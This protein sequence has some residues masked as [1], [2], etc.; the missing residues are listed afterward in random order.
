MEYVIEGL[1]GIGGFFLQPLLYVLILAAA[2]QGWWRVQRE[3]RMF[4]TRIQDAIH[5]LLHLLWPSS[6]AALVV[7]AVVLLFGVGVETNALW[8]FSL[9]VGIVALCG[10]SGFL[11]AAY[12][13]SVLIFLGWTGQVSGLVPDWMFISPATTLSLALLMALLLWAEWWLIRRKQTASA[14]PTIHRS[15]R[16]KWKGRQSVKR[17]WLLPVMLLVPSGEG[18]LAFGDYWPLLSLP[19]VPDFPVHFLL[20]PLPIGLHTSVEGVA[21]PQLKDG[22]SQKVAWL[23]LFVSA[24]AI[25]ALYFPL[26]SLLAA[27]IAIGGRLTIT[28]VSRNNDRRKSPYYTISNEGLRVLAILPGTPAEDMEILVGELIQRVNDQ[29]VTSENEFY[30]ALHINRAYTKMQVSDQR[31]EPRFVQRAFFENDHYSLGLLFVPADKEVPTDI[32][33]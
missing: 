9:L 6:L 19:I 27:I 10:G 20:F 22:L 25:G 13:F 29:S 5:E 23:A 14:S 3:R 26:L 28:M 24:L 32:D 15:K 7:S 8:L 33:E 4:N 12:T 21:K 1:F 17:V 16:G 11:S 31:G 30:D 18:V 2:I